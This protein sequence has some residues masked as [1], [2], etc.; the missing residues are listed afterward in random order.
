MDWK[1]FLH[2][3]E[4]EVE[5]ACKM[6]QGSLD[7]K[8][9]ICLVYCEGTSLP[10]HELQVIKKN[11][12]MRSNRLSE[13][14]SHQSIGFIFLFLV[15]IIESRCLDSGDTTGASRKE[16]KKEK[17]LS[18]LH[19]APAVIAIREGDWFFMSATL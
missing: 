2:H 6:N 9:D 7:V 12:W 3:A 15:P 16:E 11:K 14:L 4:P 10:V 13:E 5:T 17:V 1:S 19:K 8:N 18:H